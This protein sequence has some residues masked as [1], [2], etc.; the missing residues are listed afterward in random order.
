MIYEDLF[1]PKVDMV[2][3]FFNYAQ[4]LH[5]QC[6]LPFCTIIVLRQKGILTRSVSYLNG[7]VKLTLLKSMLKL[8]TKENAEP[9]R[10]ISI[11]SIGNNI[12][13]I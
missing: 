1:S 6:V 3:L 12:T 13:S 2:A 11:K 7:G 4:F 9:R 8:A 5:E 10:F